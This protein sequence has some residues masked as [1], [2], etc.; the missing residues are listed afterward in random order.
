[1]GSDQSIQELNQGVI[2]RKFTIPELAQCHGRDDETPAFVAIYRK[3]FDCSRRKEDLYGPTG[4]YKMFTGR[5]AT[6]LLAI[7]KLDEDQMDNLTVDDLSKEDEDKSWAW[8]DYYTERYPCMGWLVVPGE[9][10]DHW[11][12]LAELRLQ[13][14]L[15]KEECEKSTEDKEASNAANF[16]VWKPRPAQL[17]SVGQGKTRA[18]IR[19]SHKIN[20]EFLSN[21]MP[22]V[23]DAALQEQ[24]D[25]LKRIS[26]FSTGDLALYT[27]ADMERILLPAT[28]RALREYLKSDIPA[29]SQKNPPASKVET[30]QGEDDSD[31][32]SI[33]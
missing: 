5:D 33:S 18:D 11:K 13:V 15:Q 14:L 7:N 31:K 2:Q 27:L 26:V 1:M 21:L 30:L 24:V 23:P 6:R 4:S 9:D 28:A 29:D 8:Q 22:R 25:T 12:T 20:T 3:V 32:C 19:E 10:V 16:G 17:G